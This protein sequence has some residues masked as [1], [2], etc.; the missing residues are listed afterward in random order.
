MTETIESLNELLP[1]PFCRE[2][3]LPAGVCFSSPRWVRSSGGT[4]LTGPF[5]LVRFVEGILRK[6]RVSRQLREQRSRVSLQFRLSGGGRWIRTLSPVS[7][8][9]VR[10]YLSATYGDFIPGP[11]AAEKRIRLG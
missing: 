2:R 7:I 11:S 6:A 3:A 1:C 10:S 5:S 4:Q 9:R 8:C